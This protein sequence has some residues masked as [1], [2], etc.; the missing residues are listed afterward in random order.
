MNEFI[1]LYNLN[2]NVQRDKQELKQSHKASGYEPRLN[3]KLNLLALC[4]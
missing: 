4:F 1:S 3:A 2:T